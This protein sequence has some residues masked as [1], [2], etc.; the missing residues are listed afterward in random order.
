MQ[1][2]AARSSPEWLAKRKAYYEANRENLLARQKAVLNRDK[3]SESDRRYRK[4]HKA[5]LAAK[6]AADYAANRQRR[7]KLMQVNYAANRDERNVYQAAWKRAH[8]ESVF[9]SYAKRRALAG[10]STRVEPV[11]RQAIYDRDKGLCGICGQPVERSKMTLDHIVPLVRGGP[12]TPENLQTAHRSCN[13]RK[14]AKTME[15]WLAARAA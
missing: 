13:C 12:H 7:V 5:E 2:R 14:W 8:P 10:G 9:A 15:E 3:K 4:A 11:V 1:V 6:K